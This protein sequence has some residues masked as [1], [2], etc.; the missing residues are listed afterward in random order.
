MS[1]R[2]ATTKRTISSITFGSA[3]I[4]AI[5]DFERVI[6]N[7]RWEKARGN[8]SLHE[9]F[10]GLRV[11]GLDVE[12]GI[13]TLKQ[14]AFDRVGMAIATDIYAFTG[15]NVKVSPSFYSHFLNSSTLSGAL[16]EAARPQSMGVVVTRR[17]LSNFFCEQLT[18][19]SQEEYFAKD[20]KSYIKKLGK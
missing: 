1:N 3:E 17:P 12:D 11:G 15:Q 8:T 13:A 5:A 2:V 16:V 10:S 6:G 18:L 19:V 20:H 4:A 7:L 14:N 9:Q